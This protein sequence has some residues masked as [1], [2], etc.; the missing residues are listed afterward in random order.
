MLENPT[1]DAMMA[2][3]LEGK[4]YQADSPAILEAQHQ[5]V[6][7]MYRFNTIATNPASTPFQRRET[8]AELVAELGEGVE[9]RPP[10]RVDYGKHISIGPR[11]FINYDCV[12]LDV[13]PIRIGADCQFAPRVQLLTAWHPL[14]VTPRREKW[15]GGFPITVGDNVWFGAGA[16][17]LPGISVGENSVIG[18]GAVVTRDVPANV[19]VV[20]NPA[21]VIKDLPVDAYSPRP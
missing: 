20:G 16:I 17:V 8:L 4:L 13:A 14:E 6:A 5:A 18:A 11:T 9:V 1:D 10:F 7:R 3:M 19:V 15:E 2:R 21:R 12:F